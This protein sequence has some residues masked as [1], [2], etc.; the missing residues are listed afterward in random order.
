M[1]VYSAPFLFFSFLWPLKLPFLRP[2]V[3][4]IPVIYSFPVQGNLSLLSRWEMLYLYYSMHYEQAFFF[5]VPPI[6]LLS[7][8]LCYGLDYGDILILY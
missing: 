4:T 2:L 7:S 5:L 6:Y 3:F 8:F 1:C